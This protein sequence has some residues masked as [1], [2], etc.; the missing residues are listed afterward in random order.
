MATGI[1]LGDEWTKMSPMNKKKR[2]SPRCDRCYRASMAPKMVSIRTDE[3]LCIPC[4]AQ[5]VGPELY[6]QLTGKRTLPLPP[7]EYLQS[8]GSRPSGFGWA[9]WSQNR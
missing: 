2:V 9:A 3:T 4:W 6:W 8:D 5:R 1:V 7:K